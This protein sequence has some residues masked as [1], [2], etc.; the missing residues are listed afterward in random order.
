MQNAPPAAATQ[1]LQT[2]HRTVNEL[3][4]ESVERRLSTVMVALEIM[5]AVCASASAQDEDEQEVASAGPDVEGDDAMDEVP[6]AVRE[7]HP[8]Q[9][10]AFLGY[11]MAHCRHR[12][13]VGGPVY[14][15][16]LGG[17]GWK[18]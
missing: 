14:D 11:A 17:G 12:G 10:E 7:V 2:D 4:L 18:Q 9:H 13:D 6:L 5:T 1:A 15:V 8:S 3:R 16:S